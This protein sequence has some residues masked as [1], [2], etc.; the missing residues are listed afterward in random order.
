MQ[1]DILKIPEK[2]LLFPQKISIYGSV[3]GNPIVRL[4]H[5]EIEEK[6]EVEEY[7]HFR[8]K[9]WTIHKSSG[10]C[11]LAVTWKTTAN[12]YGSVL[13]VEKG[14]EDE[15]IKGLQWITP[16]PNLIGSNIDLPTLCNQVR[17]SWK[18][19]FYFV[20]EMSENGTLIHGL[21]SPQ[22]GAL[23]A[24]L[25]HWKVTDEVGTVVMPTGTGKTETM[26]A[27]LAREHLEHLLVIVPTSALRDQI[28]EKFQTFGVLQKFGILNLTALLPVV[29]KI[30]H[31][32]DTA[33]D[34]AL[35][36]RSCNVVVAT[37]AVIGGC[38]DE[39]QYSL[40]Q[41]CTHLFIDEAHHTPANTWNSFK[42]IVIEKSKP[43]L[44]FT[45]TP[46]RRDG[47]HVGG[48][49]IFRYPMRKAQ[50][51]NYFTPIT[52]I[53]IWEYNRDLADKAIARRA[54]RSLKNDLASGYDHLLMARTDNIERSKQVHQIYQTLASDLVPQIVHSRLTSQEQSDALDAIRTRKSRI[55]VCVDMLGEG[56]D[57]PQ[58]KIAALHDIHKSLAVTIQFTG[59]FTRSDTGIGKTIGETTII[60][61]AA[62]ADVEDALEDL[63][64][65]DSDW[66]L[67]LRRLSEVS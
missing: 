23:Y 47:K 19:T 25:A 49:V 34:A 27:L 56:F 60:A 8:V 37:M 40:A 1:S 42:E 7:N 31:R 41:N 39:V 54:I 16:K 24:S 53:S 64:S 66:N 58:L 43:I 52:F 20:E 32:F 15:I 30:N 51:E 38:S 36:L 10:E 5:A 35:F 22:I 28:A 45:A 33:Q 14:S 12:P 26:L 11:I 59:R 61:N 17:G 48:K 55:I 21:R 3:A 9:G 18:D 13:L 50:E 57:L 6:V 67:V 2:K 63:Y 4:E 65:K 44:Q 29:G 46:F 62:D